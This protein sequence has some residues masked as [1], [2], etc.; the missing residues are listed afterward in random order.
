[1][2]VIPGPASQKLG[3]RVGE[4]LKIGVVPVEFKRFPD[5]ESYLRF[6]DNLEGEDVVIIQTTGPP[7]NENLIQLFL[8]ADNAKDLGAKTV[9]A[10]IPYFAYAR[11]DKRFRSGEVFSVKTVMRVLE[12]CGVDRIIT[13][14]SHNPVT[15]RTF[16]V[17]VMDLSAIEL[18]AEH[19]KNRGFEGAFSLSLGK[20]ALDIAKQA[21]SVLRGEY[22]CVQTQRDRIT[23]R[24][25][26]GRKSLPVKDR[27]LIIFDDIISSGGTMVEAVKWVREQGARR[28]YAACVHPL[29][30]GDAEEKICRSGAEGIVGTD[31]VPSPV[32][33][34]SVAP[35]IATSL[36]RGF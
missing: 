14:N 21:S 22:G 23:G 10:V 32:S 11:Q 3:Q 19:F 12:G 5:G 13:V 16:R 9:T 34:V 26:I 17:P 36:A 25:T 15:L 28:I 4:L 24:V 2:I 35:L 6:E 8:M 30:I 18:I 27:D 7:Q 33:V 1:L 31:C 29:L 20:K